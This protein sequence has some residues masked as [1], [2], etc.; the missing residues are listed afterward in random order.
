MAIFMQNFNTVE[1]QNLAV[2]ATAARVAF[3]TV[4]GIGADDVRIVNTGTSACW[5]LC[6]NSSV[7]AAAASTTNANAG[8]KNSLVLAGEDIVMGKGTCAYVSAICETGGTAQLA[9]HAG[10]GS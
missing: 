1:V 7:T 10:K 8:T 2:T 9:L 4:Q 5:V 6:G 3:T